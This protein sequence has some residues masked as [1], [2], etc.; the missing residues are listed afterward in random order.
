MNV[1]QW[2]YQMDCRPRIVVSLVQVHFAIDKT[3]NLINVSTA[4]HCQNLGQWLRRLSG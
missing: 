1:E 3:L 2:D 4:S